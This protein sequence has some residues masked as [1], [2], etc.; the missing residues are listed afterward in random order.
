MIFSSIRRRMR[1]S[2]AGVIA[3]GALVLAL[4]GSAWAAKKY[5]ITSTSQ[6][7]PS[8][9]KSLQGKAGA[10]GAP[11]SPGAQGPAGSAGKDGS[12]GAPGKDG[13]S[14]TSKDFEGEKGP[15]EVGGA[16]FSSASATTYACNGE[17]GFTEA[18]PKEQTLA[19]LWAASGNE[20]SDQAIAPISFA[21]PLVSAPTALYI[22]ASGA[23][24]LSVTPAGEPGFVGE[25]S[26][27]EAAC[28]GT[29]ASPKAEPGFLCVY[30]G[31]ENSMGFGGAEFTALGTPTKYGTLVLCEQSLAKKG[32]Y[33][34][35]SWAVTAP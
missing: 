14:V 5:V 27:V 22:F 15:C 2:P 4:A 7:K 33:A 10:P 13:V 28:P 34:R 19:G 35:G 26:A 11:G 3:V 17:T 25:K 24:A 8:V 9:L 6:I 31:A 32:A 30:M 18:L 12:P 1:L 20:S 29:A 21:F 23:E 16:E